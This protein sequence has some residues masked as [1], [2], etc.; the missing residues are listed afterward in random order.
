MRTALIGGFAA[1]ALAGSSDLGLPPLH[2]VVVGPSGVG[3]SG[4][5]NAALAAT[6]LGLSV[7]PVRSEDSDVAG[8]PVVRR[9]C[10]VEGHR[11]GCTP[12]CWYDTPGAPADVCAC[13]LDKRTEKGCGAALQWLAVLAQGAPPGLHPEDPYAMPDQ[14]HAPDAMVVMAQDEVGGC[15]LR[16]EDFL[17][18]SFPA[19]V[20]PP[21]VY[22][23]PQ[24]AAGGSFAVSGR[25]GLTP[26]GGVGGL[27]EAVSTGFCLD[28]TTD[29]WDDTITRRRFHRAAPSHPFYSFL[30]WCFTIAI[31]IAAA[32]AGYAAVAGQLHERLPTPADGASRRR[33]RSTAPTTGSLAR[34]AEATDA[35][36]AMRRLAEIRD[37]LDY[38]P[39]SES[40]PLGWAPPPTFSVPSE[41]LRFRSPLRSARPAQPLLP[42]PA[43]K[44]P[45]AREVRG[46]FSVLV[47]A[48]RGVFGR[49]PP[50]S[51]P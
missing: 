51:A 32:M 44:V 9:H 15:A 29:A 47:E 46:I 26:T 42:D 22:V 7:A 13:T 43:T 30:S 14:R 45:R 49:S 6:G 38:E 2:A 17:A 16:L 10:A 18:D 1:V 33:Q 19:G 28:A 50:P 12:V 39:P 21:G 48:V 8:T 36:E 25:S 4:L 3:K 20:I 34:V 5:V 37:E 11:E 24:G 27:L 23:V 35:E 31:T 40:L 41:E